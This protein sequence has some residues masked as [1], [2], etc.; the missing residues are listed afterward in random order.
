[1]A[2]AGSLDLDVLVDAPAWEAALPEADQ[3]CRRAAR[4][5][6][7]RS[8]FRPQPAAATLVLADDVRV[9]GLNRA[10]RGIDAPTNVLSFPA[11]NDPAPGAPPSGDGV[12]DP[13]EPAAVLGDIII[14]YETVA[15][16]AH[17]DGKSLGAH[18][19]HLVVHGIL[20]LLGYDHQTDSEAE[21]ME[22]LETAVLAGLGIADPYAGMYDD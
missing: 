4:A 16:E 21:V 12:D 14:A 7:A 6:F 2:A 19:S 18:L 20:H 3:W 15:A 13:A 5:A 9:A 8:W 22:N 10:F 17:R 1:M 11:E